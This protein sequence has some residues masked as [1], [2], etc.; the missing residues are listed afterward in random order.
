MTILD[1]TAF[2]THDFP[3][4]RIDY[5][6]PVYDETISLV[7]PSRRVR[8]GKTVRHFVDRP[9]VMAPPPDGLHFEHAGPPGPKPRAL[10]VLDLDGCIT[11]KAF[12]E[13]L[14]AARAPMGLG[15]LNVNA[16]PQAPSEPSESKSAPPKRAKRTSPARSRKNVPTV[17]RIQG[18]ETE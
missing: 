4:E 17:A 12:L 16:N 6:T 9:S 10:Q 15:S 7:F 5:R 8:G 13:G 1:T 2:D 18:K 3:A 14:S 11:D